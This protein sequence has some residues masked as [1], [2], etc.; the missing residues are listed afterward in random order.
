MTEKKKN[1]DSIQAEAL[2]AIKGK[3]RSGVEVSMGVG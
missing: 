1:K 3:S 2:A